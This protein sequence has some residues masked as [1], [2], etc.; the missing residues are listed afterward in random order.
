MSV[1]PVETF[2]LSLFHTTVR[3]ITTHRARLSDAFRKENTGFNN[4][5]GKRE[6][7]LGFDHCIFAFLTP[8]TLRV[9]YSAVVAAIV[10]PI[11]SVR[12]IDGSTAC[13]S[14]PRSLQMFAP[15]AFNVFPCFSHS[16]GGPDT[17][18]TLG[19]GRFHTVL[20]FLLTELWRNFGLSFPFRTFSFPMHF[21][22]SVGIFPDS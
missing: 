9:Y 21:V 8:K 6:N 5:V 22:S 15:L 19:R 12:F 13:F 3:A 2:T 20:C 1:S 11:S 16:L 14:S 7:Q 17:L 10:F 18:H 4:V